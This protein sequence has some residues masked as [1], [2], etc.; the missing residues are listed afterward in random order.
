MTASA[1]NFVI[2]I[3]VLALAGS[4][5]LAVAYANNLAQRLQA[6]APSLSPIDRI[7]VDVMC[8]FR[9]RLFHSWEHARL[10][11]FCRTGI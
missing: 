8:A 3:I 4:L 10:T 9:D 7:V 5:L 2:A 6:I 11:I 1:K